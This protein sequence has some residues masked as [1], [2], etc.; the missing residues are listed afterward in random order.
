MHKITRENIAM[1]N[2][3]YLSHSSRLQAMD[4]RL[5]PGHFQLL[6]HPSSNDEAAGRGEYSVMQQCSKMAKQLLREH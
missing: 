6:D 4:V 5:P 2:P 1:Y 3:W